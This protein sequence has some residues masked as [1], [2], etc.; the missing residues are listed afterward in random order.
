M[1]CPECN[2]EKGCTCT[3]HVLPEREGKVCST[4]AD[5]IRK[6]RIKNDEHTRVVQANTVPIRK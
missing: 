5:L 6:E 2:Q 4:C 1:I 3:W